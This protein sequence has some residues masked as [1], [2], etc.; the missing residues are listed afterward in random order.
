MV[1]FGTGVVFI[2]LVVGISAAFGWMEDSL[3]TARLAQSINFTV[4]FVAWGY[5]WFKLLQP[6]QAMSVVPEGSRLLTVG[7]RKLYH[8]SIHIFDNHKPLA[9]FYTSM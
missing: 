7:F 8:T 3:A 5:S 6:R 9:W 2:L 4:L 1:Q